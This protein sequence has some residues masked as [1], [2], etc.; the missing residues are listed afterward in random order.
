M[1]KVECKAVYAQLASDFTQHDDSPLCFQIGRITRSRICCEFMISFRL[2][3]HDSRSDTY[4]I[5]DLHLTISTPDNT[6][7]ATVKIQDPFIPHLLPSNPNFCFE[8]IF[9]SA[10]VCVTMPIH[11]EIDQLIMQAH[12]QH[13][14]SEYV[15][16]DLNT[17]TALPLTASQ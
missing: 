8:P 1:L 14:Q 17:Q 13:L 3:C 11:N 4:F 16:L 2:D 6:A 7:T 12:T 15:A 5:D 10:I 9:L